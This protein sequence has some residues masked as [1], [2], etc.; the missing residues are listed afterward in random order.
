MIDVLRGQQSARRV[1]QG[2]KSLRS[3]GVA[4]ALVDRPMSRRR[5]PSRARSTSSDNHMAAM[6]ASTGASAE[7]AEEGGSAEIRLVLH[8]ALPCLPRR[9][10]RRHQSVLHLPHLG[11]ME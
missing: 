11:G 3:A 7:L 8:T 9:H 2:W 5:R 1:K 6:T 4:C 10:V